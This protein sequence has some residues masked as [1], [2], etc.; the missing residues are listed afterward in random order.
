MEYKYISEIQ[1]D[2]WFGLV[3]PIH[4]N[5]FKSISVKD[6]PTEEIFREINHFIFQNG[7]PDYLWFKIP[8]D[9]HIFHKIKLLI[10]VIKKYYPDQKIGTYINCSILCNEI[11]KKELLDFDFIAVNIN[12]IEPSNYLKVNPYCIDIGLKDLLEGMVGFKKSYNGHLGIYTMFF[13]GIND[14][15]DNIKSLK[16]FLID[17]KPDYIS[18]GNYVGKGFKPVSEEFKTTLKKSFDKVPFDVIFIF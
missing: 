7:N 1:H 13:S 11:A 14:D 6:F 4:L 9:P 18:I 8:N 10:K 3:A 17:I 15:I 12:S 5:S 2:S 16:D